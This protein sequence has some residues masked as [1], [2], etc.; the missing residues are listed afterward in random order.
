MASPWTCS[1]SLPSP[2]SFGTSKACIHEG[3]SRCFVKY[4][5]WFFVAVTDWKLNRAITYTPQQQLPL[6]VPKQTV[7]T[8]KTENEACL[9]GK[10]L[11]CYVPPRHIICC[12]CTADSKC[13]QM[14]TVPSSPIQ[15]VHKQ[16]CHTPK[17]LVS[18]SC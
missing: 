17:I 13:M 4:L 14:C 1:N 3:Q 2:T 9:L 18:H 10:H 16:R 6:H 15:V 7:Y 8:S 12:I 11:H 5:L